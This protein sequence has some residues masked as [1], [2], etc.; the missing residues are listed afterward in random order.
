MYGWDIDSG[1]I[2][3]TNA[4]KVVKTKPI[5]ERHQNRGKRIAEEHGFLSDSEILD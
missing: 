2:W 5:E 4:I 1:C 3:N